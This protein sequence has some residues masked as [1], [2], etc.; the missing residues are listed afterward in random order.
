MLPG[1][2][3]L[4]ADL[5]PSLS[6]CNHGSYG[7][8][9]RPVREYQDELRRRADVNPNKWFRFELPDRLEQ[10]RLHMASFI[11]ASENNAVF[12]ANATTGVNVAMA[13]VELTEGD[14]VLVTDHVYGA[15]LRTATRA[16][17][18]V[19]GSVRVVRRRPRR[20]RRRA[21]SGVRR[22]GERLD[23]RRDHRSH[24]V[25]D[26]PGPTSERDRRRRCASAAS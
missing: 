20:R 10:A 16:T 14:E 24:R 13:A 17:E 5:D 19:G 6:H 11:G 3:E 15:I 18:R 2:D 8:V 7:A 26:R 12:V 25:T 22:R 23:P 4:W 21:G 1:A 9:P